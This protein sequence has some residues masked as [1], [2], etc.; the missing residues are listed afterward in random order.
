[1]KTLTHVVQLMTQLPLNDFVCKEDYS[2]PTL[3]YNTV[4]LAPINERCLLR[5]AAVSA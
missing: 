5:C 3:D 1:M 4:D 2:D